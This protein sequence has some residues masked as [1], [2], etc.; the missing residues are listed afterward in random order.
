MLIIEAILYDLD[1]SVQ[2][3]AQ[4]YQENPSKQ[5]KCKVQDR[6]LFKANEDET[7]LIEPKELQDEIDKALATVEDGK[8]FVRAS[9]T[10]DVVRLYSEA[11]TPQQMEELAEK[12]M[13]KIK[14]NYV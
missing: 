10:E 14:E 9:G 6:S 11:K 12:I 5:Y 1:M 2:Q 7:R 3:F 13:A 8:A 4:L